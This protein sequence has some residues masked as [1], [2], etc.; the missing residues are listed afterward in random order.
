[1]PCTEYS[2]INEV[3]VFSNYAMYCVGLPSS[4]QPHLVTDL[5][6]YLHNSTDPVSNMTNQFTIYGEIYNDGGS[7]ARN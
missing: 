1:M 6:W 3:T 4:I 2:S 5:G 7:D